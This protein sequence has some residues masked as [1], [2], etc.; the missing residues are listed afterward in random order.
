MIRVTAQTERVC[1]SCHKG[2]S[3][4]DWNVKTVG[5]DGKTYLSQAEWPG[6]FLEMGP[7]WA[8]TKFRL[9]PT[10]AGELMRQLEAALTSLK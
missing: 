6:I 7:D 9:C 5:A 1:N 8:L 2:T 10:C 4:G 3:L